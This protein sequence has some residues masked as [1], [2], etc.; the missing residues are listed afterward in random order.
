MEIPPFTSDRETLPLHT[1]FFIRKVLVTHH[2][3]FVV[4]DNSIGLTIHARL[5]LMYVLLQIKKHLILL[6]NLFLLLFTVPL[7]FLI[8]S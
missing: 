2:I 6:F 4:K 5:I 8:L 3:L 7:H 1:L